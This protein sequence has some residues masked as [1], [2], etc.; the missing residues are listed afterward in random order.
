M[1]NVI[2]KLRAIEAR[3]DASI[4]TGNVGDENW[5]EID[6]ILDAYKPEDYTVECVATEYGEG[7]RWTTTEE[8]TYKVTQ[9]DGKV[10][11]FLVNRE[12]PATEMQEGGDFTFE[13][14][15]VIPQEVTITRYVLG[16]AA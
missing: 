15:E 1:E 7:G 12:R 5:R 6:D 4:Y 2:E 16:R 3:L 10:A 14:A 13:F 11:H 9:A 8:V